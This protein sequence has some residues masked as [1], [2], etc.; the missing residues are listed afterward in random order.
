MTNPTQTA[1]DRIQHAATR[2]PMI[3]GNIVII[4]ELCEKGIRIRGQNRLSSNSLRCHDQIVSW[5]ALGFA[6]GNPLLVAHDKIL[7]VL[8][9]G[10]ADAGS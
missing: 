6:N 8:T 10:Q 1:L 5:Q 7:T 4:Y 9:K 2:S 3:I